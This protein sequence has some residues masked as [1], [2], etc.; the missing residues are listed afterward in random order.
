MKYCFLILHYVCEDDTIEC[1]NSIKSLYYG[2]DY[3]IVVVD[4]FS[5]NGSGKN[6]KLK[7]SNIKNV[8]IIL[9][10]KNYGFS[11]GNNIGYLYCKRRFNPDYI[12]AINN[13]ILFNDV[14]FLK[15]IQLLYEKNYFDVLG[16][17]VINLNAEHTNPIYNSLPSLEQLKK[18][19]FKIQ[20]RSTYNLVKN[21]KIYKKTMALWH[22]KNEPVILTNNKAPKYTMYSENAVISGC[23]IIYSKLY[24][25]NYDYAFYP[26]NSM[27]FE[28]IILKKIL[29]DDNRK[30]IYSP[31]LSVIHKGQVS[32]N[33]NCSKKDKRKKEKTRNKTMVDS[34]NT[35]IKLFNK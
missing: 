10:D 24:I 35:Y 4:N 15:K 31:L 11:K 19:K 29:L 20:I 12:I 22:K 18:L 34:L 3:E 27:Y 1:I 26:M 23:C 6:L 7:Y 21:N 16:P 13:D 28:E 5:P 9:N 32:T 14:S 25:N 2:F 30:M 17:D 8:H 33:T